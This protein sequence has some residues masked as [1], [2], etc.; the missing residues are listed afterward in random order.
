MI[1][2]ELILTISFMSLYIFGV[3]LMLVLQVRY[4]KNLKRLR[5]KQLD[6][7]EELRKKGEI[8]PPFIRY[9]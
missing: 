6:E 8:V 5:Q 4:E 9:L 2:A 3:G 7:A 1:T